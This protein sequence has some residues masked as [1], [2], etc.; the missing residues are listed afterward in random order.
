MKCKNCGMQNDNDAQF[1]MS[2][3]STLKTNSS[4]YDYE[5]DYPKK[6]SGKKIFPIIAVLLVVLISLGAYIG[7]TVNKNNK[8][9]RLENQLASE[10]I[11]KNYKNMLDIN[12][13]LYELTKDEKYK[14]EAEK[15]QSLVGGQ[16]EIEKA[17]AYINNKEF[18]QAY[19]II[20]KLKN[21]ETKDQNQLD[22]LT[23]D[24][25]GSLTNFIKETNASGNFQ[26]S[27]NVLNDLIAIE[28][29]NQ[30][31]TGLL[32]SLETGQEE[33]K[34]AQEES[35]KQE[36][37]ASSDKSYI[38]KTCYVKTEGSNVRSGPSLSDAK[39]NSLSKGS[40]I[41]VQ[42]YAVDN[43]G[44]VWLYCEYGWISSKN[45]SKS[46]VA[47][48]QSSYSN[49]DPY[50]H[51]KTNNSNLREGPGLSFE[52]IGTASAGAALYPYDK[53]Y[54]DRGV[55]WFLTDYGWISERNLK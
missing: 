54:D 47:S 55:A 18:A 38:G 23:T 29:G 19:K 16:E 27:K 37:A 34:A 13:S 3:G 42:D 11:D 39:I 15:I 53:S 10:K 4:N 41:Y 24:F 20:L 14:K 30:F 1:C 45:I 33:V 8:I 25:Q 50:I 48:S 17:K 12:L 52:I 31:F 6:S 51:V 22:I 49:Y 35:A 28:P 2:C 32:S 5:R 36:K 21:S 7:F 46:K 43:R 44:V 40:T 9:N 26:T